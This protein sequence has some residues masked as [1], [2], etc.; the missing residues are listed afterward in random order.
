[1][2]L[3]P[4]CAHSWFRLSISAHN[5]AYRR[6]NEHVC[7]F[8]CLIYTKHHCIFD[9]CTYVEGFS[10]A[11]MHKGTPNRVPSKRITVSRC[12]HI[13]Q[14][15]AFEW[16][17]NENI[18]RHIRCT[19][20]FPPSD[21][22]FAVAATNAVVVVVCIKLL[23]SFW[24]RPCA[25]SFVF[26]VSFCSSMSYM[27][28]KWMPYWKHFYL[29]VTQNINVVHIKYKRNTTEKKQHTH[30][31]T[32][33]KEHGRAS[34]RTRKESGSHRWTRVIRTH[35]CTVAKETRTV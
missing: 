14:N 5:S 34:E 3:R 25:L 20:G 13:T 29:I 33:H 7:A 1:M 17:A 30:I 19:Q 21:F 31:G 24:F 35:T 9:T 26:C 8:R 23:I 4:S 11:N 15:I 22:W 6:Y 32:Q 10:N 16:N 27:N 12:L 18:K 28:S 2:S